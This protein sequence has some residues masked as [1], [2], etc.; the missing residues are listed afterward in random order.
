MPVWQATAL[1]RSDP[2]DVEAWTQIGALLL[3]DA[4]FRFARG[5]VGD[6]CSG[7]TTLRFPAPFARTAH[8]VLDCGR[9]AIGS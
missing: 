5:V 2:A 8:P 4:G 9:L 3:I 1:E 6:H 7:S